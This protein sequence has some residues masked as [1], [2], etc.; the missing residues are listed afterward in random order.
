MSLLLPCNTPLDPHGFLNPR[1]DDFL[2]RSTT[3]VQQYWHQICFKRQVTFLPG[4]KTGV[5]AWIRYVL[6]PCM[7]LTSLRRK[8]NCPQLQPKTQHVLDN[9]TKNT[10]A[11]TKSGTKVEASFRS[12][13]ATKC[14]LLQ[15]LLKY[16]WLSGC[17]SYSGHFAQKH[18]CPFMNH[19]PFFL[20]S[21]WHFAGFV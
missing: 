2:H 3:G 17:V 15:W 20:S 21:A 4:S 8:R 14:D 16:P 13:L 19:S 12:L 18:P 7:R 11:F 5:T 6:S 10:L 9:W 1:H